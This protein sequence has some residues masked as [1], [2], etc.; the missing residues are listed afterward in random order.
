MIQRIKD[1]IEQSKMT[2]AEFSEYIGVNK[3]SLSHVLSGRN[4]PSLDF[5][6]KILEAFPSIHSDWLLF[7]KDN[8]KPSTADAQVE[9]PVSEVNTPVDVAGKLEEKKAWNDDEIE[10]VILVYSGNRYRVLDKYK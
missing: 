6:M 10:Q 3:A 2:N 5:V 1:L 8:Q 7:G 9:T 4:K